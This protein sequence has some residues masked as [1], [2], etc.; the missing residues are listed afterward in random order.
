M[1]EDKQLFNAGADILK[2]NDFGGYTVPTQGLYP[3]QW[4]WDSAITALGWLKFDEPRAWQELEVLISGQWDDGMIPHIL[5]H[6]DSDTY[7]PGPDV[8]G[9][10]KKVK[11]T[12]ISQPPVLATIVKILCDE[13]KDNDLK[14]EKLKEMLPSLIRYHLW[15][16]RDRDP[17]STGLVASYHPW[18]SGMDNSPAWDKTLDAVPQVT[19]E[20]QRRDLNHIDAAERPHKEQYDRYLYLVEFFKNNQFDSAKIYRDCPYKVN[21]VSLISILHRATLDLLEICQ[22]LHVVDD[23][24]QELKAR[25]ALTESAISQLWCEE[26]KFFYSRDLMTDSLCK[27]KTNAGFLPLF[28][29]LASIE[30]AKYLA[31]EAQ[32]WMAASPYAIAS[33]DPRESKYEPQRYWRGPVWLHINWMIALGL[34]FYQFEQT[35]SQ[36]KQKTNELF[37][38]FKFYEYF[39]ADTGVGCGGNDFSWTAAIA[40]YWLLDL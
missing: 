7:F 5:F 1:T 16:Y 4:N 36:V 26:T 31:E 6:R 17:E 34:E 12:S 15:W 14:N 27:I 18:E 25:A 13:V 38:K 24:V 19:W 8:W 35:S 28:G 29:Q 2:K 40:M 10:D 33:T 32:A 22:Q 9:S 3:F 37:R 11:S 39:N 30:Q 20:Y 21:D 23:E